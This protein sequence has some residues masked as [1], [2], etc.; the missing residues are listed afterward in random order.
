MLLLPEVLLGWRL[1]SHRPVGEKWRGLLWILATFLAAAFVSTLPRIGSWPLPTG[2]GGVFGD[3][4]LRAPASVFG[5]RL[6]GVTLIVDRRAAS[7]SPLSRRSPLPPASAGRARTSNARTSRERRRRRSTRNESDRASAWLG[8]IA[9]ALLSWKARAGRLLRGKPRTPLPATA[10][11]AAGPRQEPRFDALW[12]RAG[13]TPSTPTFADEE[14]G[15]RSA[16]RP[17]PP[18]RAAR[19]GA[20]FRQRLR[21]ALAQFPDRAARLRA[22]HAVERPHRRQRRGAGKRA[23]RFR[24]A[25][26]DHQCA[27]RPGG[28]AVRTGAG[29]RHQVVARHRACRRHRPLDER[30]VGARRRRLRPQR[31]RHRTAQSDAREGLSARIARRQRLQRKRRQAAA[32]PR[33][34]HRRRVGDRRSRAHAASA[35]RRH[36]RLRQVG[37]HQH[38]DPVAGLSAAPRPVPADHGRSQ[39]ARTLRL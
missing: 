16:G 10:P 14:R 29:A 23:R 18:R 26:R 27:P 15:R 12:P 32:L 31:H 9:H 3:A 21:A 5:A 7:A 33:Q 22:H 17:A 20:P 19:A 6:N 2:L 24:R 28:D 8:M 34:D 35:D 25:R 36:H 30:G 37:R 38:H 4:L 1:L 13:A 11:A 39:D